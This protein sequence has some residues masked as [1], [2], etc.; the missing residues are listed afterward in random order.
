MNGIS[1]SSQRAKL[2]IESTR[3]QL[4]ISNPRPRMYVRSK[5]ARMSIDRKAPTFKVN[6]EKVR[7]ESGLTPPVRFAVTKGQQAYQEAWDAVGYIA[8]K[9]T[10]MMDMN[11]GDVVA[12]LAYERSQPRRMEANL[13]RMPENLPEIEW[14]MGYFSIDWEAYELIIEWDMT[15]SGPKITVDPHSVEIRL[16]QYP[17]VTIHFEPDFL[18]E[19]VKRKI[20]RKI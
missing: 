18:N 16:S 9:G 13:G 8:E 5:P 15:G 10:R 1:I 19:H 4:N 11:S 20:D 2:S 14:D 6:W 12:Q 17:N 3:A 7:S